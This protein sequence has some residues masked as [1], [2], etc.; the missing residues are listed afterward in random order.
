MF[1]K[2]KPKAYFTVESIFHTHHGA[3]Q[4][5]SVTFVKTEKIKKKKNSILSNVAQK[6]SKL[7][8]PS[9][10]SHTGSKLW[11]HGKPNIGNQFYYYHYI[12]I[13]I[14]IY[15]ERINFLPTQKSG[16]CEILQ[17]AKK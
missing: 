9:G 8:Q 6:G 5:A 3:A 12:Y 16:I 7:M 17:H 15:I 10:K 11:S 14:Y 4:I 2:T 13:Y 1:L